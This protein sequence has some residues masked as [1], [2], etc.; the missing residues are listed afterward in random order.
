MNE[1]SCS[2]TVLESMLT[3]IV[4]ALTVVPPTDKQ[5]MEVLGTWHGLCTRRLPANIDQVGWC[6]DKVHRLF[7]AI[8]VYPSPQVQQLVR[9]FK[10]LIGILPK[11]GS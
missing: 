4:S 10:R 9:Q 3:G 1:E 2:Q 11:L 7:N 5:L 6:V 8:E